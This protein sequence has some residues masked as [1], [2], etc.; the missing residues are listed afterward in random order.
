MIRLIAMICSVA[1][2][3]VDAAQSASLPTP[4]QV[5]EQTGANFPKIWGTNEGKE[6]PAYYEMAKAITTNAATKEELLRG[7]GELPS[8]SLTFAI[9]DLFGVEKGIYTHPRESGAEWERAAT[10]DY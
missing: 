5:I 8:M 9:D 10:V 7:L 6:V 1:A 2:L 3:T 4:A